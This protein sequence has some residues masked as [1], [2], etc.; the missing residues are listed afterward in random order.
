LRGSQSARPSTEFDLLP[1]LKEYSNYYSQAS[2]I[3]HRIQKTVDGL[4]FEEKNQAVEIFVIQALSMSRA[5]CLAINLLLDADLSSEPIAICRS[6]FELL[7]DLVWMNSTKDR[8][9]K[10]ERV[11]QLEADPY[12]HMSKEVRLL[13]RDLK[14]L[15]PLT[16]EEEVRQFLKVLEEARRKSPHLTVGKAHGKTDF[17]RSPPLT[18]RMGHEFR[19]QYYH[20]YRFMCLFTHPTPMLKRLHLEIAGRN[21]TP[22]Q[23]IE[24]PLKQALAY[25]LLFVELIGKTAA[26]LLEPYDPTKSEPLKICCEELFELTEKGNKQYFS[27]ALHKM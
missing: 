12:Y 2:T 9:E 3:L 7:F 21:E 24:E 17:K 1:M 15:T 27:T 22:D 14:S 4:E 10:L 25:A 19:L 26:T 5:H 13:Q 16:N 6:L 11:Y 23:L 8:H 18:E 20:I